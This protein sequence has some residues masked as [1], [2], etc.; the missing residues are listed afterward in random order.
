MRWYTTGYIHVKN[1]C[2]NRN[3]IGLIVVLAVVAGGWYLLAGNPS[4]TPTPT[5]TG[6]T[7]LQTPVN[8][9]TTTTNSTT[10]TVT[11]PSSSGVIVTYTNQGFSPKTVTIPVG[12]KVTFVNQTSGRMWIGSAPHPTHQGYDGTTASQH[13]AAGYTGP[14]P[15][16]ECSAGTAFSFTFTK[17]GAWPYHNHASAS[18]FGNVIVTAA[19]PN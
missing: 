3:I 18:D 13:C 10:T 19:T 12:T 17:V 4:G 8:T 14:A 7:S 2:M 1:K 9:T 16:D 6:T 11:L 5:G 15:F